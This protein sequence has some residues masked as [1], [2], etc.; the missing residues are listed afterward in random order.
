M[1]SRL[2]RSFDE[3]L[4]GFASSDNHGAEAL[5]VTTRRDVGKDNLVREC[6]DKFV[7]EPRKAGGRA[8]RVRWKR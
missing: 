5:S 8:V 2:P 7:A 3:G 1:P 6:G 4:H